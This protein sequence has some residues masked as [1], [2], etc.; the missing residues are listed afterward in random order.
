MSEETRNYMLDTLSLIKRLCEI[1][2]SLVP[3][4][5]S[6]IENR[7]QMLIDELEGVEK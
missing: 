2:R 3:L 4:E 7:A 5:M 1:S 6:K